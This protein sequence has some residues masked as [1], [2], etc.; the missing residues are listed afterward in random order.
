[1][2][3]GAVD[4]RPGL[5]AE[6]PGGRPSPRRRPRRPA[7]G[8]RDRRRGLPRPDP[9]RQAA[10]VRLDP[11]AQAGGDRRPGRARGQ[12]LQS[13]RPDDP[14][15]TQEPSLERVGI[16]GAGCPRS[17][18]EGSRV[19]IAAES[20]IPLAK[21]TADR[22]PE[23]HRRLHNLEGFILRQF[24]LAGYDRMSTPILEPIELHERKSGAG[25]VGKLFEV[26]GG[27]GRVC[28]RPE[29][30]A[31]IVRAYAAA[32]SCPPLPWRV[33]HAGSAFRKESPARARPAPRVPPGWAGTSGRLGRL[34]RCRGHLAGL[35]GRRAGRTPRFH[36]PARS[37]R[38]DPGNAR[39]IGPAPGGPGRAR[40]DAQRGRRRGGGMSARSGEDSTTSPSGFVRRRAVMTC[41]CRSMGATM[42][43][44][45]GCSGPWSRSSTAGG[46]A[47]K[48]FKGS[49]GSGTLATPGW[50]RSTGSATRPGRSR[51]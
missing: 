13:P 21:G 25:I 22:L 14:R 32:E 18:A 38:I 42:A 44:L 50:V 34:R 1:M 19:M 45:T 9:G 48:L 49:G 46:P 51:S 47:A 23:D 17:R 41:R 37:R 29:L 8:H 35:V 20:S 24:S 15:G 40:R 7:P 6:L 28:L 43:G 3:E 12:D 10:P 33:S 4:D 2:V 30:T 31:G 39:P 16:D 27:G 26:P 11:R 5:V 36:P